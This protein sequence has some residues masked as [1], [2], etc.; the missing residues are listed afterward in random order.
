MDVS[1][2]FHVVNGIKIGQCTA[3]VLASA[4]KFRLLS[5][6]PLRRIEGALRRTTYAPGERR[7]RCSSGKADQKSAHGYAGILAELD[8]DDAGGR[9]TPIIAMTRNVMQGDRQKALEA[10]MNDYISKPIGL[11]ELSEV[12]RRWVADKE[13]KI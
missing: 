11:D 9:R 1:T 2:S 6:G 4:G 5:K 8:R 3:S 7:P 10:G 13:E 12:L